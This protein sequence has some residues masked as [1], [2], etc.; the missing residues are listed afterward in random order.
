MKYISL[1]FAALLI[2][3]ACGKKT[4]PIPKA[5]LENVQ[6]PKS[7]IVKAQ[8]EGF[9]IANNEE[10]FLIVEKADFVGSECSS[11]SR[12]KVLTPGEDFI[13]TDVQ[14]DQAYVYKVTKKTIKYK[15]LSAPRLYPVVFSIPPVVQDIEVTQDD[16]AVIL[17]VTPSSD[18]IRMDIYSGGKSIVQTGYT[19]AKAEQKDIV[20]NN[21]EISLMDS[22]GNRGD[23]F[24]VSIVP[25]TK[26]EPLPEIT[27]LTAVF[28]GGAARIVWDSVKGAASYETKVCNDVSCETITTA[29]PYAVYE[30]EFDNCID[31]TVNAL[32]TKLRSTSASYRFC[33]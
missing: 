16:G 15:L 13:D 20:N 23:R 14:P 28:I 21:V 22:Y 7:V 30:K 5:S 29:V 32:N 11:Y 26:P 6:Y 17:D 33:K 2:L 19:T 3:T 12:L 10:A 8:P 24:P 4:D 25:E 27:G 31:I 18:F 9:F 1:L